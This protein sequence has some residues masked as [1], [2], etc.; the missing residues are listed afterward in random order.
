M[1]HVANLLDIRRV[2][3]EKE[4]EKVEIISEETAHVVNLLFRELKAIFPAFRQA[5]PTDEEFNRAKSNWIKAFQSAGIHRIE[6]LKFG[7][8]KCRMSGSPFAPS[9]GQFISW[10]TPSPQD[11]G[12]PSTDEAYVL[13]IQMNIQFSEFKHNDDRVDTVI[14][15]AINQIGSTSYREMKIDNAKK[16]FKTYYEIALKQF[17]DGEL[18]IIPK[19]LPEKAEEH[20]SD[21][22]RNREAYLKSMEAIRSMGINVKRT[23]DRGLQEN[24][25]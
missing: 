18:K 20:P 13:S 25:V 24:P 4:A 5:W 11:L 3:A 23:D 1:K 10:C 16:T 21:K 17:M 19:A 7:V 14:R 6:Q 9:V 12:F 8:D 15:H 22:Q 2:K